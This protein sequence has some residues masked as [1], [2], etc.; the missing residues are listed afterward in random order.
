[1]SMCYYLSGLEIRNKRNGPFGN[2]L[3]SNEF[4]RR[5]LFA[6]CV[7]SVR[8]NLEPLCIVGLER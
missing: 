8:V 2:Q 7:V 3:T 5:P 6:G 4:S 1:M